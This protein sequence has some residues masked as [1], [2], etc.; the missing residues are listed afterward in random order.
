MSR[1]G[2]TRLGQ[3]GTP[4]ADAPA[5]GR[6]GAPAGGA[7]GRRSGRRLTASGFLWI[8]PALLLCV[9]LIYYCIGYT[10]YISTL[11]WDGIS[12]GPEHV[13]TRNYD[14]I[15]HDPVFWGAIRH[16]VLFFAVTFVVQTAIGMLFA[17]LL[18]SKIKFA[19]VYKVIVFIPVVLAPAI[20]AP[21]FRRMFAPDGQ[22]NWVLGHIGLSSLEQPWIG[23]TSTAL[24]VVMAITVWQWTGLT[25]VLYFAAMSQID[26]SVLEAARMDGAGNLRTITSIIWPS[27]R[28]TTLA[29]AILS[30]I[31][32]M[33]TFDVPWLVTSAGPNYATEFLGTYIYRITIPQAHVG[34]GAAL[35]VILLVVA[36]VMAVVLQLRGREKSGVR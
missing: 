14:R 28:G 1:A 6:P 30:A 9:G 21:V 22:F 15:F 26:P 17:V 7:G 27:V 19:V 10:A 12:P 4:G 3:T 13:G 35:S 23:Q 8:L 20:T 5:T 33:K 29:L 2:A 36:L 18:H 11:N 31:G 24:W 34:Y 25:F 16:T 32:V